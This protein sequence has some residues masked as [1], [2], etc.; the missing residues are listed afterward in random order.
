M[1][2]VGGQVAEE[3][4]LAAAS[5]FVGGGAGR[6]SLIN[7]LEEFRAIS[8]GE[9]ESSSPDQVFQNFAIYRLGIQAT[10]IVLDRVERT[11][12]LAIRN[13]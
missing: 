10:A 5:V 2:D 4:D 12:L 6:Q 11:V 3:R 7:P 1:A 8:P 9:I 13:G